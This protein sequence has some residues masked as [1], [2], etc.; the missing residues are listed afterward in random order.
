MTTQPLIFFGYPGSG[1]TVQAK[2]MADFFDFYYLSTGFL[3]K[4]FI[5]SSKDKNP[6]ARAR[7]K[8]GEPQ[9]D[10][11]IFDLVESD[12]GDASIDKGLILDN[13]PFN[14]KQK[15]WLDEL[16]ERKKWQPAWAIQLDISKETV[17]KRLAQRRYCL[18]CY[19]PAKDL[20]KAENC[21]FCGGEISNRP[22]D[23]RE[24]ISHRVKKY[25]QSI[26]YLKTEF[27]DLNRL[28]TIDGEPEMDLVSKKL[29]KTIDEI[30]K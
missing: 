25:Q 3:V 17:Y 10:S 21:L 24:I 9:Q 5:S 6:E 16:I 14:D 4:Q 28:I 8:K 13:F 22:D 29:I 19:H 15:Q 26:N 27:G 7:Y 2:K 11:L 20:V 23:K 12:L 1:K 30:I 18:S